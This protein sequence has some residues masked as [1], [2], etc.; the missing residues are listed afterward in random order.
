MFSSLVLTICTLWL[1]YTAVSSTVQTTLM[2]QELLITS[3]WM[4]YIEYVCKASW[5][6]ITT[7]H[8]EITLFF[9]PMLISNVDF[10]CCIFNVVFLMFI[11][12]VDFRCCFLTIIFNVFSFLFFFFD[13]I[14]F[15]I[16]LVLKLF[17][18]IIFFLLFNLSTNI[19][20]FILLI[21]ITI[22]FFL[23][24]FYFDC[25]YFSFLSTFCR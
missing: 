24:F 2:Y 3:E 18:F 13:Y 16:F 9:F 6:M 21:L 19:F 7:G 15:K 22:L 14:F 25:L 11:F 5:S 4:K 17:F 12:D 8:V 20:Y 1:S 10:Q 23:P